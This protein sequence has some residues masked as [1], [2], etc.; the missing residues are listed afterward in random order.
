MRRAAAIADGVT[1]QMISEHLNA[2][3]ELAQRVTATPKQLCDDQG[4]DDK[5]SD[6]G[7]DR[8][9]DDKE[10]DDE[11]DD[12]KKPQPKSRAI[13]QP[14]TGLQIV[15]DVEAPFPELHRRFENSVCCELFCVLLLS[16][17]ELVC[18][19]AVPAALSKSIEN[20][21]PV[22]ISNK[23]FTFLDGMISAYAYFY[24]VGKIG[25]HI[26]G[27]NAREVNNLRT[28]DVQACERAKQFITTVLRAF[29]G[30]KMGKGEWAWNV[31][32]VKEH[33]KLDLKHFW[34]IVQKRFKMGTQSVEW[35][36]HKEVVEKVDLNSNTDLTTLH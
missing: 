13:T 8:S 33:Y 4:S 30:G 19:L 27:V 24:G 11:K 28:W 35:H 5:G 16:L 2:E 9:D 36:C 32:S 17:S 21:K 1:P 34:D 31:K 7:S 25:V 14:K 12:D 18:N 3:K 6:K 23:E 10:S 20:F 22:P 26:A 15:D 29:G